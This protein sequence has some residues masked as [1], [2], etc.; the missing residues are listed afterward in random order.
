MK[1]EKEQDTNVCFPRRQSRNFSA[2]QPLHRFLD[3]PF[4]RAVAAAGEQLFLVYWTWE[5]P[6]GMVYSL[7]DFGS[8]Q[9]LML[10]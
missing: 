5:L 4:S 2:L 3:W 6:S 8:G 1:T 7:S 9:V 10:I